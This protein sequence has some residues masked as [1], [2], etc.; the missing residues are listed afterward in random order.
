MRKRFGWRE[1]IIWS[2][3]PPFQWCV[4]WLVAFMIDWFASFK[5]LW[6]NSFSPLHTIFHKTWKI[7][8]PVCEWEVVLPASLPPS[9]SDHPGK[10]GSKVRT[11]PSPITPP[12]L[13]PPHHPL[14]QTYNLHSFG[15][16]GEILCFK[17]KL[18]NWCL[19]RPSETW[20]DTEPWCCWSDRWDEIHFVVTLNLNLL[21]QLS[22]QLL[23]PRDWLEMQ[24]IFSLAMTI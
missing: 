10:S 5:N 1:T 21:P 4:F 18:F 8:L 17:K 7:N 16:Q 9:G 22:S 23:T 13:P 11:V 24:G 12:S 3:N 6:S 20:L 15:Q 2:D 14:H 19:S